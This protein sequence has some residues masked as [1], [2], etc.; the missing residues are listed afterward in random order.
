[1]VG[2]MAIARTPST[3]CDPPAEPEAAGRGGQVAQRGVLVAA[4]VLSGVGLATAFDPWGWGEVAPVAVIALLWCLTRAPSWRCAAILGS[5]GGWSFFATHTWW[6]QESIGTGAW[7]VV[8]TS[9][10]LFVGLAGA[11]TSLLW[12]RRGAP[13]L[14]AAC[15][16][17]IEI[18]R[19]SF[20]FGGFPWGQ[21][22]V[23]VVDTPWGAVLPYVGV[24]GAGLLVVLVA[25]AALRAAQR[26]GTAQLA[27][28]VVV[29]AVSLAPAALPV[30]TQAD[31]ELSVAVVQGDV[32]GSGDDIASFGPEVT[33]NHVRA[34]VALAERID[35]G[36]TAPVDL[37]VWPENSTTVDP[38]A[39]GTTRAG[40][41]QAVGAVGVPVLVGGI[42]D[43]P[44]PTR[45]LN[46]GI[47]WDATG[48][49]PGRYTKHHP[50][51]FGEYI[52]FRRV[53]GGLSERFDE[54]PRDMIAGRGDEPLDISGVP[55]AD[56]ICFDVAYQDVIGSQVRAGARL[57]VVQTSNATFVGT[58]QVE[59]QFA[60]TRARAAE[61]GRAVAVAS[62]NG[63]TGLI[64]PDGSVLARSP[65][66][67]TSVLQDEL[68]LTSGLTPAVRW[69]PTLRM[70]T[71][72]I[73]ALALGLALWRARSG[74]RGH[75]HPSPDAVARTDR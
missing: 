5:V 69:G 26:P 57:V 11:V 72:S 3:T 64:A 29:V 12:V 61:V 53:L 18:A 22:G 66:R 60:I 75:P 9:Q 23:T 33:A 17:S 48:P 43:A 50:V 58:D 65:L 6:L 1:M 31:G 67:T 74:G 46:Q 20:P 59:Q 73:A 32:P 51:P 54:I 37:V 4:A 44:D 62:T 34:T 10:G 56:A 25:A 28:A 70:V 24:S 8:S 14:V 35:G 68:P 15:W 55:V 19:L 16:S 38:F 63:L 49:Q 47:V 52:P 42:V 40:I 36:D 27:G 7:V 30:T 21:V 39:D 71:L 45:V 41:E 2:Q 13:V